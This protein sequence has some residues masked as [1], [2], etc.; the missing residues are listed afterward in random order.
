MEK[1]NLE[2]FIKAA[3]DPEYSKYKL[4]AIMGNYMEFLHKSKLYP[5]FSNLIEISG[6]LKGLMENRSNIENSFPK[7]LIRFDIKKKKPVYESE[8]I[9]GSD[10]DSI[11]DFINWSMP[12]IEEGLTE[13]KAIYDFV[14]KN[15]EIKEIGIIPL[16]KNEGYLLISDHKAKTLNV[17]RY[18][19]ILFSSGPEPLRSLKTKYLTTY[20]LESFEVIKNEIK[21]ELTKTYPELPNP[22]AYLFQSEI[23]FPF[24]ETILPIAKRKLMKTLAA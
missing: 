3:R 12:Q 5:V 8:E 14:E 20:P 23:D 19:T 15:S 7:R 21:I 2:L 9:F 11:F 17:Y 24:K 16:Y 1:L 18:E 13:G 10:K 6:Q 22:A 4:L